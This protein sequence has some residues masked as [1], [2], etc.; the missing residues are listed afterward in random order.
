[1][2]RS[3]LLPLAE[4]PLKP[5]VRDF[6]FWLAQA[7]G[8]GIHALAI[9]DIKAFEIPVLGTTDGFIPTMVTPPLQESQTLLDEMSAAARERL[10]QLAS[11]CKS[12]KISCSTE[13]RTGMP[14][15]VVARAAV[16]HDIV[17]MARSGYTRGSGAE[18][19]LDPMVSQVL[20]DSIRPVLVVGKALG[21]G[22]AVNRLL[23]AYDGSVHAGRALLIAGELG[24][25]A[26]VHTKLITIAPSED[27][28]M[29]TMAPAE[30]YLGNHGVTLEKQVI[31][32]GKPSDM[33]CELVA[34]AGADI[35]IMG[36]F[37]H[38]PIREM[39]F[40]STTEKVLSHC[41]ST[42]ILQS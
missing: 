39:L 26:G 21:E 34:S 16:A 20:R 40:G 19:R 32:G 5:G 35:L 9:I 38:G 25:R 23:V 1:M 42:V 22:G 36:A 28:G 41:G 30:T 31:V 18:G 29:E 24:A 17:I 33:I 8:S 11:E 12:R 27:M 7:E 2:I 6:A 14:G 15:E 13:I 10:D 4:G 37:G 3:I